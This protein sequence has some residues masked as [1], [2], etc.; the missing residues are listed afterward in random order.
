M[1]GKKCEVQIFG[2]CRLRSSNL[3]W[4][5]ICNIIAQTGPYFRKYKY[6]MKE[7]VDKCSV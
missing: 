5:K 3:E 4:L 1:R 2:F 7:V 6:L